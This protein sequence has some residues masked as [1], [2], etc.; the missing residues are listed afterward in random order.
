MVSVGNPEDG[1]R[2]RIDRFARAPVERQRPALRVDISRSP[3]RQKL[4]VPALQVRALRAAGKN[5]YVLHEVRYRIT[6]RSEVGIEA[7]IARQIEKKAGL[8]CGLGRGKHRPREE[9]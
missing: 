3:V 9:A 8:F 5:P 4:I 6:A 2:G 1:K 7:P